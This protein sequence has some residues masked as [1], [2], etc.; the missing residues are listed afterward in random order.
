M[1][2]TLLK[3]PVSDT[4]TQEKPRKKE[5]HAGDFHTPNG[6]VTH[7]PNSTVNTESFSCVNINIH[8]GHE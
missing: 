3:Y 2:Y 8:F 5:L 7:M 6:K 4:L 1:V